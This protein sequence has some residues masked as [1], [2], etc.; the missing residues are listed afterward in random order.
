MV[1]ILTGINAKFKMTKTESLVGS[2]DDIWWEVVLSVEE[3][4]CCK[5]GDVGNVWNFGGANRELSQTFWHFSS[6][7]VDVTDNDCGEDD[8]ESVWT[9]GR[10]DLVKENV[11]GDSINADCDKHDNDNCDDDYG[12]NT[13]R[14]ISVLDLE[15]LMFTFSIR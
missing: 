7:G 5:V 13:L 6:K 8:W 11:G 2:I 10:F 3:N 12:D 4:T 9:E 15:N 1:E 14:N